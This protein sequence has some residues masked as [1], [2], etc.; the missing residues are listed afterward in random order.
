MLEPAAGANT[1]MRCSG[2]VDAAKDVVQAATG[3]D[4]V[5]FSDTQPATAAPRFS[6][7]TVPDGEPEAEVTAASTVMG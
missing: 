5:I 1:A 4:G 7:V 2:D 3:F 6:N